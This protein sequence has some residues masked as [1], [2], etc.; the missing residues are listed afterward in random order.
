MATVCLIYI[1]CFHLA[2][3]LDGKKCIILRASL[4]FKC[5]MIGRT[6]VE[7]KHLWKWLL[8]KWNTFT[9]QFWAIIY[10]SVEVRLE[11]SLSYAWPIDYCHRI[12]GVEHISTWE[13]LFQSCSLY[14][15]NG[16]FNGTMNRTKMLLIGWNSCDVSVIV[17]FCRQR[18]FI[19]WHGPSPCLSFRLTW[20]E[21][22]IKYNIFSVGS[23][24][25][26][27]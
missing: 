17:W 18:W 8:P 23:S 10:I 14:F 5:W 19:F 4:F 2:F 1:K 21:I 7:C 12:N 26:F 9:L 13:H 24:N 11:L 27:E 20:K 6:C 16:W 15:L 25:W 22:F 3:I